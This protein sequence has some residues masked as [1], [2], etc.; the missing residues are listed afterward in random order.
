MDT[1]IRGKLTPEQFDARVQAA[2]QHWNQTYLNADRPVILVGWGSCSVAHGAVETFRAIRAWISANGNKA[3]LRRTGCIGPDYAEPLVDIILPNGPRVSYSGITADRVPELLNT[4]LSQGQVK[5]EWAFC[6]LD[7]D[8]FN[9]STQGYQGVP[10]ALELD[11][12]RLQKRVI[13][14]N[15]GYIDPES[16][17]DYLARGG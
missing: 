17:D 5:K 1:S 3:I 4:V 7:K 15:M 12:F 14:R 2:Q 10:A 9:N 8:D 6:V 16:I 13:M 11:Q